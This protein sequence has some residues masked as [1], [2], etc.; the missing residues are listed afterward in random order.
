MSF[1]NLHR[2]RRGQRLRAPVSSSSPV[3]V[4][5]FYSPTCDPSGNGEGQYYVGSV[6]LPGNGGFSFVLP[7]R[8]GFV[9]AASS[10]V[11]FPLQGGFGV[12]ACPALLRPK[13]RP[14]G[15]GPAGL[16]SVLLAF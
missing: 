15:A 16:P 1:D 11:K 10:R 13:K 9:T 8:G 4:Q 3:V 12:F 5:L 2:R 6:K 14:G 7:W